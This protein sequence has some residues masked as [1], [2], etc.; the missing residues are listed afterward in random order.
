MFDQIA[1]FY[2]PEI[3]FTIRNLTSLLEP[4]MLLVMGTVVVFIALSVLLPIF[5]LIS[6][7]KK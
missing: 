6:V 3:E 4:I 1:D 7:I 5:N 2:E